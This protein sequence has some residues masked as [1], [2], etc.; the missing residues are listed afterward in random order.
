MTWP[1]TSWPTGPVPAGV[2][3]DPLLDELFDENGPLALTY[4]AVVIHHGR[5]IAERYAGAI[6]HFDRPA[7]Q[8]TA[9]TKLLSWSM[10]KS[11]LHAVIG[12]LVGDGVLELDARAEVPGWQDPSDPR[13]PITLEQL[14]CMRDGLDF[15]EDY[16][17]AG[18]SDVIEMLFGSGR[19][20]VAGFAADRQ[21]VAA[22]D[23][24]FNYSSG[25]SNI[26]SGIVARALGPG[27][28]YN[29]F[30]T[31]R[32]FAP[33]GM[34][35]AVARFDETGTWIASSYVHCTARDFARFGYLYLRDGLWGERQVLPKGWVEHGRRIRSSSPL[36]GTFY[37]AHWWIVGDAFDSFRAS[38]YEGQSIL[39]VPPLDLVVVRLGKTEADR[40]P[41]L[42]A[43]RRRVIEAF[44]K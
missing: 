15:L 40:G 24:R 11:M 42:T 41:N 34:S 22:P 12:M 43:W 38:G 23:T 26:I 27:E 8:V 5:L 21:L 32:L 28:P 44:A 2:A 17:D 35:S 13:H 1:T 19:A 36:D 20:D 7:E 4:A 10:A 14:L 6:E 37:G 31:E 9:E 30:L 39:I 33:I 16:V 18:R 3:L 29:R 25:T